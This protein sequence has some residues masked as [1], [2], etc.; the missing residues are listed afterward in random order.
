MEFRLIE[1]NDYESCINLA[2]SSMD[3]LEDLIDL[4]EMKKYLKNRLEG[5]YFY[6]LVE[7]MEIYLCIENGKIIGMG[8]IK[9]LKANNKFG[10][11]D[12]LYV[13]HEIKKKGIGSQIMA[14]LE[15]RAKDRGFEKLVLEA[16]P[17]AVG[18]YEKK[19]FQI[20]GKSDF[21]PEETSEK[22]TLILMEK[23]L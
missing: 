10:V 12:K 13:S 18:F 20:T 3:I 1:K 16:F 8:G 4:P 15:K 23:N 6:K 5:K 14:V 11:I 7:I 2:N 9:S 19:G 17:S 21:S 22:I